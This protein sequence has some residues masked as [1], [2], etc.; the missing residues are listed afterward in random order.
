MRIPPRL[1]GALLF[2]LAV[3]SSA[4]TQPWVAS[5]EVQVN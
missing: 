3:C 5:S 1:T 4:Q 2:G